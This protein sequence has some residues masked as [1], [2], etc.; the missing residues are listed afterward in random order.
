MIVQVLGGKRDRQSARVRTRQDRV[1]CLVS[2]VGDLLMHIVSSVVVG[3][4]QRPPMFIRQS[5]CLD[6]GVHLVVMARHGHV[7]AAGVPPDIIP[8]SQAKHA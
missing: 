3:Q 6:F 7:S 1:P 2:V 5:C 4:L 8:L